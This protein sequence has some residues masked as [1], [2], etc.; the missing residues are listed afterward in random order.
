M[1]E[2][3]QIT[4]PSHGLTSQ[5]A[6]AVNLSLGSLYLSELLQL[7]LLETHADRDNMTQ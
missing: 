1:Q 5:N 7:K 3:Q 6:S 2:I 4:N